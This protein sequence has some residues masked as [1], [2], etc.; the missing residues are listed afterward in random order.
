VGTPPTAAATVR[1][2]ARITTREPVVIDVGAAGKGYLVDLVLDLLREG[3]VD[4]VVVDAGGD[5]RHHGPGVTR[6]GLEHPTRPD[7]AVGAAPL[8][9]QALC[10]SAVTRRAWGDGLHHV[11]DPRTGIPT[12]DILEP[13]RTS[14]ATSSPL[15]AISTSSTTKRNLRR[16]Q[17]GPAHDPPGRGPQMNPRC[18]AMADREAVKVPIQP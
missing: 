12:R 6:V 9:N 16:L 13:R 15:T 8:Q 2:D 7:H 4:D 5:L 3:G 11:L 1:F 14:P 17:R 18:R 10:A